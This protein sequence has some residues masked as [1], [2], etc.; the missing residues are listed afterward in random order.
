MA[1]G[2]RPTPVTIPTDAVTLHAWEV[3]A[4][5]AEAR[6][7]GRFGRQ[8]GDPIPV[9]EPGTVTFPSHVGDPTRVYV[10]AWHEGEAMWWHE[11]GERDLLGRPVAIQEGD[12]VSIPVPITLTLS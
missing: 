3:G 8:I 5:A 1:T 9:T 11:V 7:A 2:M 10:V 6:S 12:T 4:T